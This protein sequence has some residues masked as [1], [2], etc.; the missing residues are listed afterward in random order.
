MREL[1]DDV[2]YASKY[3]NS[4]INATE[5]FPLQPQNGG[6]VMVNFYSGF[7]NCTNPDAASLEDVV[8]TLMKYFL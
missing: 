5:I 8:G 4:H 7:I 2:N 3:G 6:I 1:R